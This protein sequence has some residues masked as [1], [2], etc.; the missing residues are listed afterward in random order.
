MTAVGTRV[1]SLFLTPAP[2]RAPAPDSVDHPGP[3]AAPRP[4]RSRKRSRP[5]ASSARTAVGAR[6]VAV[7]GGEDAAPFAQDL[8]GALASRHRRRCGV[9]CVWPERMSSG[10]PTPREPGGADRVAG[11]L[12]S[13]DGVHVTATGRGLRVQLPADPVA[14]V[15][16]H[17]DCVYAVEEVAAV[18]LAVCGPRPAC[19][20]AVLAE[21]DHLVL[22]MGPGAPAGLADLAAASLERLVPADR[23]STV[24][25]RAGGA[26]PRAL[27]HR[28]PV[29][30]I[31][32]AMP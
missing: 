25:P 20:D 1:A 23:I 7:V 28:A 21:H 8:A 32:E 12:A 30:Q 22:V 26:L 10:A 13:V 2:V 17:R 14:A 19:F 4:A 9:V 5:R 31:L 27:R 3:A 16:A 15:A 18:V 24:V 11:T 6:T 29:R